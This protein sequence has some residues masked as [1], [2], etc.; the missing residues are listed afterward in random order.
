[1]SKLVDTKHPF[2]IKE[3]KSINEYLFILKNILRIASQKGAIE[4]IAGINIPIRWSNL[5][6]TYVVDFGSDKQRDITGIHLDNLRLHYNQSSEV[7]NSINCVLLKIKNCI[8]SD[9]FAELYKLKKNENRFLNLVLSG[10]D[11]Y[12]TGIYSRCETLKRKGIYS[13][14]NRKS[15]IIDN[16]IDF[17]K[18]LQKDFNFISIQEKYNITNSYNSI[19]LEFLDNLENLNLVLKNKNDLDFFLNFNK[20][21]NKNLV[22]NKLE[23]KKYIQIL[24]K[25]LSI[26]DDLIFWFLIYHITLMFNHV[27][28]ESLNRSKIN[29]IIL[30]DNVSD[31]QIKIVSKFNVSIDK[32]EK[33]LSAP[34]MP[35]SF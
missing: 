19:Y 30:Y 29:N 20:Y 14:K 2:Q 4:K 17:F 24:N 31:E 8:N 35:V 23:I 9:K 1:M 18:N 10:N 25:E 11:I 6:N 7:F 26:E 21:I 32:H 5:F 22:K 34:L 28:L 12:C 27:L 16:S 13:S 33:Y 3:I 15:V